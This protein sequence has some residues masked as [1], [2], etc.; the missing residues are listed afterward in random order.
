LV[1]K[2]QERIKFYL[3]VSSLSTDKTDV[4]S[5]FQRFFQKGKSSGPDS[6][7]FLLDTGITIQYT[8]A[9]RN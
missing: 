9:N 7:A 1:I 8:S 6:N 2:K 5:F 4:F 3:S